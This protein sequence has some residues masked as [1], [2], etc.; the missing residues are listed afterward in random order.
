[1]KTNSSA[2]RKLL[3]LLLAVVFSLGTFPQTA[4]TVHAANETNVKITKYGYELIGERENVTDKNL[5]GAGLE[6]RDSRGRTVKSFTSGNAPAE[7]T[8]D[9][10]TY[11]VVETSAPNGY[12]KAAPV[13]FEVK[14]STGYEIVKPASALPS[15]RIYIDNSVNGWGLLYGGYKIVSSGREYNLYCVDST[16]TTPP[17]GNYTALPLTSANV[18]AYAR[19]ITLNQLLRILYVGYAGNARGYKSQFTAAND[20][21]ADEQFWMATQYAIAS[22]TNPDPSEL[23]E[24]YGKYL[25]RSNKSLALEI[26]KA[27]NDTSITIPQGYNAYLYKGTGRNQQPAVAISFPTVKP[28]S[29]TSVT[30]IKMGDRKKSEEDRKS[31]V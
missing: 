8:L 16:I 20:F 4:L 1:M 9:P 17:T 14:A 6:I 22:I 28:V 19:N 13:Q 27:A 30:V 23:E 2:A 15:G 18:E 29:E 26:A 10:G 5:A 24:Y 12:E 3:S 11:T 7:F 31:V 25:G 21:S